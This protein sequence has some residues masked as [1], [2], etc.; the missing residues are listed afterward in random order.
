MCEFQAS[1]VYRVRSRIVG[2]TKRD[3]VSKQTNK[4]RKK[5]RREERK[6][7]ERKDKARRK[8]RKEKRELYG[9]GQSESSS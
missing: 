1:L 8:T 3:P 9:V 5:R 7:E 6:E 2:T 4:K